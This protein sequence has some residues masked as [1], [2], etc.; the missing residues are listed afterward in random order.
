MYAPIDPAHDGMEDILRS[1]GAVL[2]TRMARAIEIRQRPDGIV[3]R[4]LAVADIAARLDGTWSR[5]EHVVTHVDLARTRIA[6]AARDRAGNVAGPH[7]R[8]LRALGRVIDRRG[9]RDVTL[10]QHPPRRAWLLWHRR[11]D[12]A[13]LTLVTLTNDELLAADTGAKPVREPALSAM[14]EVSLERLRGR[15]NRRSDGRVARP[16]PEPREAIRIRPDWA[17]WPMQVPSPRATAPI[18]GRGR[19]VLRWGSLRASRVQ[20][21]VPP[22]SP[23]PPWPLRRAR[24][25]TWLVCPGRLTLRLRLYRARADRIREPLTLSRCATT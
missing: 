25:W 8:C 15:G 5:L 19:I 9:L 4:A 18:A 17:G 13:G 1:L 2:D 11:S 24:R 20:P 12:D 22:T 7:E 14:P 10:I 6:A 23:H 3:I 21:I 16:A